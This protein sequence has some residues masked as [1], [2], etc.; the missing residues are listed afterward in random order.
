MGKWLKVTEMLQLY[1]MDRAL[2]YNKKIQSQEFNNPKAHSQDTVEEGPKTVSSNFKLNT[3][4]TIGT[5][6]TLYKI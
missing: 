5:T 4:S 2:F 6:V 1:D 3:F